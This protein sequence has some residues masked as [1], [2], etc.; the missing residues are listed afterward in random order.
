MDITIEIND[1]RLEHYSLEAKNE[2]QKQL[3]IIADNLAEEANRIEAGRR[4]PTSN[5]EVTQ[6]DV[7]TAGILSKMNQRDKKSRWWYIYQI[8]ST[9]SGVFSGWLFDEDKLKQ[10]SW[11]LYIF[12][13]CLIVFVIST[14]LTFTKDGNK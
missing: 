6:S 10:E 9:F 12:L 14:L 2:L 8:I 11:R 5:S 1:V 7:S 3:T 13:L 4:L